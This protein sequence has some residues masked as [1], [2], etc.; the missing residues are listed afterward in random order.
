MSE[1]HLFKTNFV[2]VDTAAPES[3]V[4]TSTSPSNLPSPAS[5][6]AGRYTTSTRIEEELS[7]ENKTLGCGKSGAVRLGRWHGSGAPCAV[8]LRRILSTCNS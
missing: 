6:L 8:S 1:T 5:A 3:E 2:P 7:I 4:F